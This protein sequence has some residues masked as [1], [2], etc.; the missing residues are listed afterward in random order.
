MGG[1]KALRME[2]AWVK[3]AWCDRMEWEGTGVGKQQ[4]GGR[5]GQGH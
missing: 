1:A 5:A 3:G 4:G 2:G